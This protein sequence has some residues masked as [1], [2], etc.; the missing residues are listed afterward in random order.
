[1]RL[2]EK[3]PRLAAGRSSIAPWPLQDIVL[4]RGFCT[5]TNTIICKQPL[6]LGT[7]LTAPHC[8]HYCAIYY[9]PP[10]PLYCNICHII[11]VMATSSKGQIA[12]KGMT[13]LGVPR[14][15]SGISFCHETI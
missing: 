10:T 2:S 7:P 3:M 12:P 14:V 11:L 9:T 6:Y 13:M 15:P 5:R 1:M 4:Y 8:T